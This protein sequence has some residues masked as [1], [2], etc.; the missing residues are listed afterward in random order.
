MRAW[1]QPTS[2]Y[3]DP[4][5]KASVVREPLRGHAQVVRPRTGG[6]VGIGPMDGGRD[7]QQQHIHS[8]PDPPTRLGVCVVRGSEAL[9]AHRARRH[10]RGCR[11]RCSE[12]ADTAAPV[13][14]RCSRDRCRPTP[15][16]ALAS[17]HLGVATERP[18]GLCGA[19]LATPTCGFL[20]A[21]LECTDPCLAATTVR[22]VCPSCR[23]FAGRSTT[24][25]QA[26][27]GC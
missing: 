11:P 25:K 7:V 16:A 18:V 23:Q 6:V 12:V 26:R 3:A 5:G 19:R 8:G 21:D 24:A 15:A 1:S 9:D 22:R 4:S 10:E 2:P 20:A 27:V 14:P 17:M 13:T